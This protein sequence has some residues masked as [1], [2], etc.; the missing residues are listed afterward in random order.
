M[1]FV[2]NRKKT[3][4]VI[5]FFLCCRHTSLIEWFHTIQPWLEIHTSLNKK[6]VNA[7]K[8][9]YC[10][11]NFMHFSK[12]KTKSS[13]KGFNFFYY[14]KMLENKNTAEKVLKYYPKEKYNWENKSL[15]HRFKSGIKTLW[16]KK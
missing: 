16:I 13:H 6:P 5:V 2:K 1:A 15:E 3:I 9:N 7:K 10:K 8:R 4:W 12:I 11:S 14:M